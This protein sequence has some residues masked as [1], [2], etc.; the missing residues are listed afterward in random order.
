[1][2]YSNVMSVSFLFFRS[3]HRKSTFMFVHNSSVCIIESTRFL[4]SER[5]GSHRVVEVALQ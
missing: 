5:F 3:I 1:M 2:I 4:Y